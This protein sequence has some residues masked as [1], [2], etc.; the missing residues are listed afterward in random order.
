MPLILAAIIV[1]PIL[2]YIIY[3]LFRFFVKGVEVTVENEK[4]D[5]EWKAYEATHDVLDPEKTKQDGK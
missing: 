2:I 1:P 5:R 3:K 4:E